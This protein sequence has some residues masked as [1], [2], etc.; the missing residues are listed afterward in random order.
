LLDCDGLNELARRRGIHSSKAYPDGTP[1]YPA[2]GRCNVL[3]SWL[4]SIDGNHQWLVPPPP[5]PRSDGTLQAARVKF[6]YSSPE[7]GNGKGLRIWVDEPSRIRIFRSLFD[8]PLAP[9]LETP[10]EVGMN[11]VLPRGYPYRTCAEDPFPSSAS[12][13]R[14]PK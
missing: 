12:K 6:A 5:Y 8:G 11:P 1:L 3:F 10:K 9:A 7:D 13:S 4:R 14:C 2:A